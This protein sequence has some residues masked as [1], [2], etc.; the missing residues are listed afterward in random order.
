MKRMS[1]AQRISKYLRD[2]HDDHVKGYLGGPFE[3]LV[4]WKQCAAVM[5]RELVTCAKL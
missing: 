5:Q 4:D 2:D 1:G 3:E